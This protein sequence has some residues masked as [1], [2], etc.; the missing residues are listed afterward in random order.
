MAAD[1]RA[2][3]GVVVLMQLPA[4]SGSPS[5]PLHKRDIPTIVKGLKNHSKNAT[6]C[7]EYVVALHA[8]LFEDPLREARDAFSK[9]VANQTGG[10]STLLAT[11]EYNSGDTVFSEVALVFLYNLIHVGGKRNVRTVVRIVKRGGGRICA[12]II[13]KNPTNLRVLQPA[14]MVIIAIGG[15]D[16]KLPTLARLTGCLVNLLGV[17]KSHM[18]QPKPALASILC[19]LSTLSRGD[20]NLLHMHKRGA[21]PVILDICVKNMQK[22]GSAVLRWACDLLCRLCHYE[23]NAKDTLKEG[24]VALAFSMCYEQCSAVEVQAVCIDLLR[25]LISLPEGIAQFNAAGGF[26]YLLTLITENNA[27]KSEAEWLALV[28]QMFR[29][30]DITELP[31]PVD[32]ELY[33]SPPDYL[34]L[35]EAGGASEGTAAAA[36]PSA[37]SVTPGQGEGVENPNAHIRY[38]LFSPELYEGDVADETSIADANSV[39]HV[40]PFTDPRPS[41]SSP[42]SIEFVPPVEELLQ[43]SPQQRIEVIKRQLRRLSHA[44]LLINR[45][46]YDDQARDTTMPTTKLQSVPTSLLTP[47]PPAT[48]VVP[49]SGRYGVKTAAQSTTSSSQIPTLKFGSNFECGNLRRAIQVFDDEYDLILQPDINTNT[50]VQWFYF[51]VENMRTDVTYRFNILNM[52]KPSS[53]FNEG[54]RPL[55]F[56]EKRFAWSG[57]GWL[58]TGHD[59]CYFKNSYKR[60]STGK[61]R[62][63]GGSGYYTLSLSIRFPHDD[64]RV[65]IAN[66]Y[67]YSYSD[68]IGYLRKMQERRSLDDCVMIQSLCTTQAGNIMPLVTITSL[69][70]DGEYCTADEIMQRGVVVISA[71]VHPGESNASY[72]CKGVMDYLIDNN[73]NSQYLRDNFVWKIVPMLNPD[74][75]VNGNHRCSLSGKDLNREFFTPDRIL[76]PTIYHLKEV[77]RH[78]KVNEGRNVMLYGDFHGHSRCR[79]FIIFACSARKPT[80]GIIP[81]RVFPRTLAELAPYFSYSNSTYKVQRS[82]RTTGRVVFYRELG[83]RMS[84][85]LEG[86]MMGGVGCDFVPLSFGEAEEEICRRG[87]LLRMTTAHFNTAHYQTLG[88][89]FAKTLLLISQGDQGVNPKVNEIISELLAEAQCE[90]Q[91]CGGGGRKSVAGSSKSSASTPEHSAAVAA[92]GTSYGGAYATARRQS[93]RK[94]GAPIQ[95]APASPQELQEV[96][97]VLLRG[98]GLNRVSLTDGDDLPEEDDED[99]ELDEDDD[100]D[101]DG[102][103]GGEDDEY[104]DD[105][106]GGLDVD[107]DDVD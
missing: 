88:V 48:P 99:V 67:P 59:I 41:P 107:G 18:L 51:S 97:R 26:S 65:Y 54:Q 16:S 35:D 6:V 10:I 77:V 76:N 81:E 39:H 5:Q 85:T 89:M 75:V 93:R 23:E 101:S 45:V 63:D 25:Q 12:S 53:T 57:F 20:L 42:L 15:A 14:C 95:I 70:K 78:W 46:V 1:R 34:D 92:E 64:D 13:N 69:K 104:D 9:F 50:Y 60:V 27:D 74:G 98:T 96:Y 61:K 7:R 86:S 8:R 66:C 52:E 30:Y 73:E 84:F 79:N 4:S 102:A 83:I 94:K 32:S 31:I 71:R 55:I 43:Q 36:V 38:E 24:G 47:V 80:C 37:N 90:R 68:L 106:D 11:M 3:N 19:C 49:S 103:N 105:G 28:N 40:K 58:R 82:K 91:G 33:W 17:C 100:N 44:S 56:S 2:S 62:K 29:M 22:D 21:I 87:S 72:M